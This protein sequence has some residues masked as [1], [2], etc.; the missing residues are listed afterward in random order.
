MHHTHHL[1]HHG[2]L[3]LSLALFSSVA[4][5]Q[6]GLG[7]S[8]MRVELKLAPGAQRSGSLNLANDTPAEARFRT[9]ILDFL[10]DKEALPQF[11][12][13]IPSE[14]EYS[15]RRWLAFNP[16]E[17]TVPG[18]SEV[19]VRYTLRVPA[20]ALPRTY[21]CAVGFTSLPPVRRPQEQGMGMNAAVRVVNAFYITIG[22]SKPE[23]ELKEI[24]VQKIADPSSSGLRAVFRVENSGLTNLRGD[25]KV[26]LLDAAGKVVETAD[27]PTG[28]ILPKR[29]QLLPLTLKRKLPEGG[30]TIRARVN[31][32][33]G[34]L[35]EATLEFQAAPPQIP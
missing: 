28:I 34:E 29:T 17:G 4:G 2:A 22:D 30:Y 14:A 31:L 32:G 20:D 18:S 26:D 7:L 24:V 12:P 35:Q 9:E 25:G 15:C 3:A 10:L 19:L 23:G 33:T 11:E 8:P 13:D 27:F 6:V 1:H 21:H 16:M 5:A